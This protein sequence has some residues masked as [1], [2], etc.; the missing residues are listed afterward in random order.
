[1]TKRHS[2]DNA[3]LALRISLISR[4]AAQYTHELAY[5]MW[6]P[7]FCSDEPGWAGDRFVEEIEPHLEQIRK[8]VGRMGFSDGEKEDRR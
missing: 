6:N 2:F 7:D 4:I 5:G 3:D 1:M 8:R